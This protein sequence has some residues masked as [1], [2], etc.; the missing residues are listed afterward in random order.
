M[1]NLTENNISMD[2]A[3]SSGYSYQQ[4]LKENGQL[5]Q[6]DVFAKIANWFTGAYDANSAAWEQK[7]NEYQLKKQREYEE[8]MSSSQYQ[9][10]IKDLQAAGFTNPYAVLA[11]G[12]SGGSNA[13]MNSS[14]NSY[15]D[16]NKSSKK[17]NAGTSALAIA[18]I[19]AIL[20]A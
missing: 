4:Y 7:Y 13:S 12:L 8:Y 18:K 2:D 9:R 11:Q 19:I 1:A 6:N 20:A 16:S 5:Q 10:A 15:S 14:A 17:G 3:I